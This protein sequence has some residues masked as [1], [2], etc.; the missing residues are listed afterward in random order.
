MINAVFFDL[1][2]T[3]ADT[4]PDLANAL[5]K[6]RRQENLPE[7]PFEAIRP[8]VSH[9]GQAMLK[10]G[11]NVEPADADY[12]GLR[13]RFLDLY[14]ENIAEFTR[15]FEGMDQLLQELEQRS[16]KWG[17]ITNKPSWLTNPLMDALSLTQRAAAIVS[18][19]T[20]ERAK[21]HPDPMFYACDVARCEPVK[22]VYVGDAERDIQAGR[23]AGM[24]TLAALFGYLEAGDRPEEWGA[25]AQI[26]HPLDIL[27]YLDQW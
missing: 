2:G 19:D 1:D 12:P 22:C 3:L 17:V 24:R 5:N 14:L 23:A 15:L 16:M 21:P 26:E 8:V 27:Q 25:D 6:L 7:L 20:A 4:A 10:V 13:Q 18:G 9:G 11:F